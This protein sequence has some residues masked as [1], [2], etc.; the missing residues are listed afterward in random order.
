MN[1]K[2][3]TTNLVSTH[4][5]RIDAQSDSFE[6]LK[7]QLKSF[8]YL[9]SLGI[10]QPER[11]LYHNFC[12]TVAIENGFYKVTLLWKEYHKTLPD[13]YELSRQRLMG[14]LYSLRQN[15]AMLEQYE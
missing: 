14:L 4:V 1:S 13:N 7:N 6:N 11:T 5:L 12:S 10:I 8:W 2:Q 15:P 3:N 9:E